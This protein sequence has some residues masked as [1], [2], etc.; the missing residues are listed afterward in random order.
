MTGE[1]LGEQLEQLERDMETLVDSVPW[2]RGKWLVRRVL[3]AKMA[4]L[5]DQVDT[6]RDDIL[7]ARGIIE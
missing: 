2:W 6:G 1:S 4:R 5:R 7:R 3:E